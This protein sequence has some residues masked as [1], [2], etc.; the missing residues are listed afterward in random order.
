[1]TRDTVI[2]HRLVGI[3]QDDP[4]YVEAIRIAAAALDKGGLV[5]FPTETVYGLGARIDRDEALRSIFR[6]KGRPADNPLIVHVAGIEA[7]RQVCRE[8]PEAAEQAA[9]A[10]WPGPI[11]LVLPRAGHVSDLVTGGLDTVAVRVPA[12]RVAYDLVKTAGP[13]AAPSANRSGRPSPTEAGHVLADL[14][15]AIEVLLDDGPCTV[16]VESTVLDLTQ[17]PPTILR[18]GGISREDLERVLGPVA[19]P[20]EGPELARSPG[21]RYRHYAPSVPV[22][23]VRGDNLDDLRGKLLQRIRELVAGGRRVG[24]LAAQELAGLEGISRYVSLGPYG[25]PGEA[26]ARLFAGLRELD[27]SGVDVIVS[28]TYPPGG[29]G[30]A[31]NDRILR[32]AGNTGGDSHRKQR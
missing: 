27:R 15:Q 8:W 25:R 9:R 2:L 30:A 31:I 29:I 26:A 32:A 13:L 12:Q 20:G 3:P 22:D 14:G 4:R 28:H 10:F 6:V 11:T 18:P 24:L 23:V 7:A 21:T 16:G 1:M 19:A 17:S 5:A